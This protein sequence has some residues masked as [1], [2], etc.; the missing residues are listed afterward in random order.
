M[1]LSDFF[2]YTKAFLPVLP[3]GASFYVMIITSNSFWLNIVGYLHFILSIIW[4]IFAIFCTKF[5]VDTLTK[6]S[7]KTRNQFK[8]FY[9]ITLF[10]GLIYLYITSSTRRLEFIMK[11]QSYISSGIDSSLLEIFNGVYPMQHMKNDF[12]YTRTLE[13]HDIAL[14]LLLVWVVLTFILGKYSGTIL[15]FL[16]EEILPNSI[17]PTREVRESDENREPANNQQNPQINEKKDDVKPIIIPTNQ[18]EKK[19]VD[20]IVIIPQPNDANSAKNDVNNKQSN[21]ENKDEDYTSFSFVTDASADEMK[22]VSPSKKAENNSGLNNDENEKSNL[23][24]SSKNRGSQRSNKAPYIPNAGID[25]SDSSSSDDA[26]INT[27]ANTS[28]NRQNEQLEKDK[29]KADAQADS[30]SKQKENNDGLVF[31]SSSSEIKVSKKKDEIDFASDSSSKGK[32]DQNMIQFTDSE[33]DKK[34]GGLNTIDF[35]DSSSSVKKK[36]SNDIQFADSDSESS[37]KKQNTIDFADSD[38]SPKKKKDDNGLQFTDSDDDNKKNDGGLDFTDSDDE[39]KVTTKKKKDDVMF[40]DSSTSS[41]K[42]PNNKQDV[43]FTDSDDDLRPR[44]RGAKSAQPQKKAASPV[45][46]HRQAKQNDSDSLDDIF[47]DIDNLGANKRPTTA[48]RKNANV[49]LSDDTDD[50]FAD[51]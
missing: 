16:G 27:W 42:K 50:L 33:D 45:K 26:I 47:K 43:M 39:I 2:R 46:R 9:I 12:I 21:S 29:Q 14:T 49:D 31:A 51:L 32:K 17:Q 13:S 23:S 30:K 41:I 18:N 38:D 1:L 19:D 7:R 5:S 36:P 10:L 37:K 35:A 20:P 48:R 6:N 11:M 28:F 22:V 24:T 25:L 40:T 3:V 44:R 15:S 34:N 4:F 8:L